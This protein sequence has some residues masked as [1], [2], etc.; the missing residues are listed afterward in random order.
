M[1]SK[2]KD[3]FVRN[4]PSC[5]MGNNLAAAQTKGYN[6]ILKLSDEELI[7]TLCLEPA[8]LKNKQSTRMYQSYQSDRFV[9]ALLDPRTSFEYKLKEICQ[10]LGPQNVEYKKYSVKLKVKAHPTKALS[11][12]DINNIKAYLDNSESGEDI[13]IFMKPDLN[14]SKFLNYL[15]DFGSL[16]C[17][18]D[19][20]DDICQINREQIPKVL[21]YIYKPEFFN[22]FIKLI[23]FYSNSLESGSSYCSRHV[24]TGKVVQRQDSSYM[25]IKET[26]P[27]RNCAYFFRPFKLD[28]NKCINDELL[29]RFSKVFQRVEFR[30]TKS[31]NHRFYSIYD[32][33][34]ANDKI[35]IKTNDKIN[36]KNDDNF[37]KKDSLPEYSSTQ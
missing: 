33:E 28:H 12:D 22:C 19:I 13:Y 15:N 1:V 27:H 20:D 21:I 16:K 7:G 17:D 4:R 6:A 23:N 35:N 14:I 34:C 24:L 18:K 37:N 26:E 9:A 3:L 31:S 30:N 25:S 29:K 2:L 10:I 36:I 32:M 8:G 5:E 11:E